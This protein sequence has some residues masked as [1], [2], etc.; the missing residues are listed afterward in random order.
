MLSTKQ[1]GAPLG[2]A[3]KGL[4]HSRQSGRNN[5]RMIY[6]GRKKKISLKNMDSSFS[7]TPR[8]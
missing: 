1:H 2:M 7:T 5:I 8:Y 3:V 4:T 6:G